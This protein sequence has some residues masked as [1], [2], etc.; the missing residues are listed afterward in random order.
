MIDPLIRRHGFKNIIEGSDGDENGVL[1]HSPGGRIGIISKVME[2]DI[3]LFRGLIIK[4]FRV[5]VEGIGKT[6]GGV[7]GQKCF[8]GEIDQAEAIRFQAL[9]LGGKPRRK[10]K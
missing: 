4:E 8:G 6:T 1:R 7:V 9:E 2:E 3:D 5:E 10:P